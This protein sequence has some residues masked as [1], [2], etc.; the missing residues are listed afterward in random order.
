VDGRVL[1]GHEEEFR[2]TLDEL[3][4]PQVTWEYYHQERPVE[5]PLDAP[6]VAA[7]AES[8]L[9][10]DPG[11]TVIPYCMSGGTDAKQFSRLG[12]ACYGYTPLVVPADYDYY[13]MFHGVNERVPVSAL[14]ASARIVGRFLMNSAT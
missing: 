9:A 6:I 2:H 13:A 4:G 1:A 11:A 8:L 10:E 3:T 5:A 12:M 14:Q 7:M